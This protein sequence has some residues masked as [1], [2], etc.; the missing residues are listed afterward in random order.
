MM[1]SVK[2]NIVLQKRGFMYKDEAIIY[3]IK[4]TSVSCCRFKDLPIQNKNLYQVLSLESRDVSFQELKK[5][6]R[7]K[8]LQLHPDVCPSSIRDECTKKFVELQKAYEVLSDPNS[9][10]MYD[11][12]LILVEGFGP[13]G[14]GCG[15][16]DERKDQNISRKI[17]EMQLDGLKKRSADR[18]L[19]MKK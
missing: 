17:W 12:E 11:N 18:M 8:A 10:R 7:T 9:R 4:N 19:N 1:V 14:S 13:C 2:M 6:Y 3:R 16:S 5:A 15:Y